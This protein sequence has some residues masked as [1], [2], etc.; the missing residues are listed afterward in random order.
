MRENIQERPHRGVTVADP[1]QHELGV[2]RGKNAAYARHPHEVHDHLDTFVAGFLIR[3]FDDLVKFA[4]REIHRYPRSKS[5]DLLMR[6]SRTPDRFLFRE[7][8]L[9]QPDRLKKFKS[10]RLFEKL[11]L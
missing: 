9:E 10:I 3:R 11:F 4:G 6:Q 1:V 7:C 8:A 2:V 5:H